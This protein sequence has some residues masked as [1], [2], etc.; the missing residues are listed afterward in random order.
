MACWRFPS[1]LD[2]VED[3]EE[4]QALLREVAG[5]IAFA[6]YNL[7]LE[8]ARAQAEAALRESEEKYRALL[9]NIQAGVV[10]HGADSRILASNAKAQELLGLTEDQIL[11]KAAMDLDWKF[12]REDG[13]PMPL[14]DYPVNQVLKTQRPLQNFIIGICR[15]QRDDVMW[16]MLNADPTFDASDDASGSLREII[17]TSMDITSRASRSGAARK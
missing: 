11:G 9:H 10:V 3:A 2:L 6:L 16:V 12:L 14:K 15:P 17:V 1:R 4:E 8:A 13:T 5:D 7:E